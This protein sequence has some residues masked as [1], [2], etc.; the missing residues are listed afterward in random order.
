MLASSRKLSSLAELDSMNALEQEQE[1][2]AG[3]D[4]KIVYFDISHFAETSD[5]LGSR[6]GMQIRY[7]TASILRSAFSED[8]LAN[9][10]IDHFILLTTADCEKLK[11]QI[12]L[13]PASITI[14]FCF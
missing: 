14:R 13:S 2:L 3:Q 4:W 5:A 7:T 1:Q 10:E 12:G 11:Q 8:L 6:S 9:S